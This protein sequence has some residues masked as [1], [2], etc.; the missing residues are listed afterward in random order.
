[1][2]VKWTLALVDDAWYRE[3]G[4]SALSRARTAPSCTWLGR[5]PT[6]PSTTSRGR[7]T[8]TR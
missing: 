4:Y 8:L 2:T 6:I 5:R 1:M 7:S 3:L